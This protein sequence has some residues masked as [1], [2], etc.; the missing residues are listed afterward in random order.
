MSLMSLI[1]LTF[2]VAGL[3]DRQ[4]MSVLCIQVVEYHGSKLREYQKEII[5]VTE[6]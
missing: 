4:I 1:Y 2:M 3:A 6:G 5:A